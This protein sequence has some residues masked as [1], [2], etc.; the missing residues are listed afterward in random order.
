MIILL[1]GSRM[2]GPR[3]IPGAGAGLDTLGFW[4]AGL[5]LFPLSTDD[6][7]C[8]RSAHEVGERS[9]KLNENLKR[10]LEIYA[11]HHIVSRQ[12]AAMTAI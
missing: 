1:K 10:K 2:H 7:I 9:R 3:P 11:S 8:R 12:K 6:C 4:A 5:L